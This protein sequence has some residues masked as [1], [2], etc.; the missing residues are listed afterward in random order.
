MGIPHMLGEL[1]GISYDTVTGN[2]PQAMNRLSDLAAGTLQGAVAPLKGLA[3][4]AQ[5]AGA[6]LAPS[7]IP[8][9]SQQAWEEAA[10][11]GGATAMGAAI[12]KITKAITPTHQGMLQRSQAN[13]AVGGDLIEAGAKAG[14]SLFGAAKAARTAYSKVAAPVQRSI[15]KKLATPAEIE[16]MQMNRVN[17]GI[18]PSS[19]KATASSIR[20]APRLMKTAPELLDVAVGPEFDAAL[21]KALRD[22]ELGINKAAAAVPSGTTVPKRSILPEWRKIVEESKASPYTLGAAAKLQK[23]IQ[24]WNQ[25]PDNIPFDQFRQLKQ[26]FLDDAKTKPFYDAHRV[27]MDI[28]NGISTGLRDANG[29]YS[30]VKRGID[31]AGIIVVRDGAKNIINF[32]RVKPPKK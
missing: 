14:N 2:T 30:I 27:L 6:A 13:A 3:T 21:V 29:A 5:G 17:E 22:K 25:L 16:K 23:V 20:N 7:M 26:Q 11:A 32:Q 1:G 12:P 10:Q 8:A 4:V 15:A 9:P 19:T 18:A 31:D 28:E 24:T